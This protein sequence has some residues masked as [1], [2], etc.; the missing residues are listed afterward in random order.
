MQMRV[1]FHDVS[2]MNVLI[3]YT[4]E[5]HV[6]V[7]ILC[8]NTIYYSCCCGLFSVYLRPHS[9]VVSNTANTFMETIKT[10]TNSSE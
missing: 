8:I 10:L 5:H 3:D 9:D 4:F 6:F 7:N 1:C 2:H